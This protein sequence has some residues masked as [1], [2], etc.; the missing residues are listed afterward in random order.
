VEPALALASS[1]DSTGDSGIF[2]ASPPSRGVSVQ[3]RGAIWEAVLIFPNLVAKDRVKY[4]GMERG[5]A[6]YLSYAI[7]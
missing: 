6:S 7:Y 4:Y 1:G 5:S 2:I 3:A